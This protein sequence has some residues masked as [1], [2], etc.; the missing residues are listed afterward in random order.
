MLTRY[1]DWLSGAVHGDLGTSWFTNQPVD[2]G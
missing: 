2:H 1:V